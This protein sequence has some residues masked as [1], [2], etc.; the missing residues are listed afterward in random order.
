MPIKPARR[1]GSA[2]GRLK[3]HWRRA[4][5]AWRRLRRWWRPAPRPAKFIM[6]AL[7]VLVLWLGINWIYQVLR[8]PSELFFPVSGTL[9]K[10][11]AETWAE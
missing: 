2:A 5:K 9:Y 4:V 1:T 3:K 7:I 8:K 6:A 11:P 10:S